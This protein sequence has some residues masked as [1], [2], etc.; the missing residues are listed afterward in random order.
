M[1]V[2]TNDNSFDNDHINLIEPNIPF[3]EDNN[4][5]LIQKNKLVPETH[6]KTF[7]CVISLFILEI[8][9]LVI[10]IE[11][12]FRTDESKTPLCF[13]ILGVLVLIPGGY[14]TYK[15]IQIYCSRDRDLREELLDDIPI[16]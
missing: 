14:F 12:Y 3:Q 9:L 11:K 2:S 5:Q 15:F 7:Y 4:N 8:I 13:I 16:L 10:G 6:K 1:S